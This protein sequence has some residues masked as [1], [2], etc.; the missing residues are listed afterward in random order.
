M[1]MKKK[2]PRQVGEIQPN[3]H[4]TVSGKPLEDHA[5]QAYRGQ[6]SP[7]VRAV[8]ALVAVVCVVFLT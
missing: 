4:S 8:I 5:V 7:L 2:Q 6:S 1:N 3:Q